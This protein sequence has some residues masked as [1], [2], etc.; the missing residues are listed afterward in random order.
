MIMPQGRWEC[1][2]RARFSHT[3]TTPGDLIR[4]WSCSL[5]LKMS[6]ADLLPKLSA[7][8]ET[9][10]TLASENSSRGVDMTTTRDSGSVFSYA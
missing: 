4:P 8:T 10:G 6:N 9:A 2:K 1:W 5:L 7:G 3:I